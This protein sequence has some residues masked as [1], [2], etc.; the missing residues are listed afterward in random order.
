MPLPELGH[1]PPFS[2]L[3]EERDRFFFGGGSSLDGLNVDFNIPTT[4]VELQMKDDLKRCP[5]FIDKSSQTKH[6]NKRRKQD[7]NDT[8]QL[9]ALPA[10]RTKVVFVEGRVH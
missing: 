8:D 6:S 2:P 10:K 7:I 4:I 5:Q 1:L 3:R 9:S